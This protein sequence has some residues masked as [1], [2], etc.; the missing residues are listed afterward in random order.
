MSNYSCSVTGACLCG[1]YEATVTLPGIVVLV[2]PQ[3]RALL[4]SLFSTYLDKEWV[5]ISPNLLTNKISSSYQMEIHDLFVHMAEVIM[6]G[7][8]D[9]TLVERNT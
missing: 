1:S 5:R 4:M 2:S 9:G 8:S 7:R 6:H 3:W